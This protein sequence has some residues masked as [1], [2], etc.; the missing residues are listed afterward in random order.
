LPVAAAFCK[1]SCCRAQLS[2]SPCSPS[3]SAIT[4]SHRRRH[5]QSSCRVAQ[6]SSASLSSAALRR[7][8]KN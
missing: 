1:T 2:C 7:E 8:E 4:T 5:P 3:Q 6:S